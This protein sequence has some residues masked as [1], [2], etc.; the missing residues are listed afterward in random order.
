[1]PG[2]RP[3]GTGLT[4]EIISMNADIAPGDPLMRIADRPPITFVR[5]HG[6]WLIDDQGRE[7][8]DFVQGWAVNCLGHSHPAM[9]QAIAAQAETLINASPGYHTDRLRGLAADLVARSCM[10]RVFFTNSG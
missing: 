1:M 9:V 5:G 8:L 4:A 10:D 6:S 7:Y 2:G 3:P